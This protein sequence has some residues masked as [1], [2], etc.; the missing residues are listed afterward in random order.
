MR[1]KETELNATQMKLLGRFLY[2][3][4]VCSSGFQEGKVCWFAILV[5]SQHLLCPVQ[6]HPEPLVL[7]L[8]L[9]WIGG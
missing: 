9:V 6:P 8:R 3:E 7:W 2:F 4:L 5:Q 1:K